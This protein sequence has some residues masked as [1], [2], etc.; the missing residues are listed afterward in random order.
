MKLNEM[1]EMSVAKW[2]NEFC[3]KG[4]PEK[5]RQNLAKSRFVHHETHL[6]LLRHEL[7]SKRCEASD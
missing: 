3:S 6:E 5:P 2:W 7:G 4:K 1:N